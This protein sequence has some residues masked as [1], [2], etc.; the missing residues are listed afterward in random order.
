MHIVHI[1]K[2]EVV[3]FSFVHNNNQLYVIR[4]LHPQIISPSV[5]HQNARPHLLRPNRESIRHNDRTPNIHHRKTVHSL[6]VNQHTVNKLVNRIHYPYLVLLYTTLQSPMGR[7]RWLCREQAM[8][9][10][11][12]L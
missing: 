3:R 5:S 2:I 4:V 12:T 9:G 10:N 8:N 11:D 7:W 6:V 1:A